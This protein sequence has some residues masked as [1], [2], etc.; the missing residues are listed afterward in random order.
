MVSKPVAWS[1]YDPNISQVPSV[2]HGFPA[3]PKAYNA[4]DNA[5]GK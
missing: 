3:S 4:V 5:P 2:E 1:A